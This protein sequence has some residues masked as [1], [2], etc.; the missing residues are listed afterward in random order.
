MHINEGGQQPLAGAVDYLRGVRISVLRARTGADV[1]DRTALDDDIADDIE[2]TGRV[3]A[4]DIF[5]HK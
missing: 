2:I 3:N 4:T 5:H 1:S